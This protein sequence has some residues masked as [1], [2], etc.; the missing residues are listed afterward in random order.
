MYNIYYV[1]GGYYLF[2]M[3]ED[4]VEGWMAGWWC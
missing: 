1:L 2:I 3:T 4:D